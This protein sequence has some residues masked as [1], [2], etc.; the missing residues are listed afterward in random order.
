MPTGTRI[1][2]TPEQLAAVRFGPDGLVPAIVQ[3]A[4]TGSVLM[5]AWMT[6]ETLRLTRCGAKATRRATA[7]G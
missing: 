7:S 2:A 5:M 4:G 1:D 3:E 6:P